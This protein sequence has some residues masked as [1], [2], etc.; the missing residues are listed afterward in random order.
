[1][2]EFLNSFCF[3]NTRCAELSKELASQKEEF[4]QQVTCVREE[5]KSEGGALKRRLEELERERDGKEMLRDFDSERNAC[6]LIVFLCV[7]ALLLLVSEKD[8]RID[9]SFRRSEMLREGLITDL[10]TTFSH[11]IQA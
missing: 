7:S 11:I 4:C 1:M 9:E 6:L 2:H 10:S 5:L 3:S 8:K